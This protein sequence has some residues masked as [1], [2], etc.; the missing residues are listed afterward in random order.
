MTRIGEKA[1]GYTARQAG[2]ALD[3][4]AARVGYGHDQI[5]KEKCVLNEI[6][7]RP[8]STSGKL[9]LMCRFH[10]DFAN[11]VV[12]ELRANPDFVPEVQVKENGAEFTVLNVPNLNQ[13][14]L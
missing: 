9:R 4:V 14:I 8:D 10:T 12:R 3:I 11:E 6:V 1:G 7:P 5:R 13:N 2:K